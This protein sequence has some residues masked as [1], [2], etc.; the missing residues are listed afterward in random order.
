VIGLNDGVERWITTRGQTFFADRRPIRF[1]GGTQE[2]TER[3]R[4]EKQLLEA[5]ADLEQFAYSVSHDLQEPIRTISIYSELVTRSY[6]DTIDG[7]GQEY[8]RFIRA[9]ASRLDVLVQDLLAYTQA[10]NLQAS[11][12]DTDAMEVLS[13]ALLNLE[14]K[15][16]ENGGKVVAGP[17]PV[18]KVHKSHLQQ[19]F[20]NL[21]GNALKYHGSAPPV[22]E[23]T[24]KRQDGRWLFAVRDNG[25]GIDPQYHQNIFGMFKRLHSGQEFSGTG[26]GL[27]ICQRIV[28]RH[29]GKIWVESEPGKGSTFYFTLPL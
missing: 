17:L 16:S 28:E 21:I 4:V 9:G 22:I 7:R 1:I 23:I 6:G 24:A 8:L 11:V 18:V 15:M 3:K 25:I 5:N 29:N 19:I 10:A 2:V 14:P 20:Q 12:E 13:E 27:A 26:M